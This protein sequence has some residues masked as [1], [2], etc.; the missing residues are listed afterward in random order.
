MKRTITAMNYLEVIGSIAHFCH[1]DYKSFFDNYEKLEDNE[2]ESF[3]SA[4]VGQG[5]ISDVE[6]LTE[7]MMEFLNLPEDQKWFISTWNDEYVKNN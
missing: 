5:E 6:E 2:R 3:V 1:T 7:E 4:C